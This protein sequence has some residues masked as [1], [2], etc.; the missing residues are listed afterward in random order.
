MDKWM[1]FGDSKE[2]EDDESLKWTVKIGD[3][4][5]AKVN[6]AWDENENHGKPT[7]SVLWM[8]PEVINQKFQ[9][10]YTTKSDVYSFAVVLYELVAGCLPYQNKEP[11]VVCFFL[12]A[13]K[14]RVCFKNFL[15]SFDYYN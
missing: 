2:C 7:G 15:N 6:T 4:G 13:T 14:M 11:S 1:D 8:A 10:P 9:D 12:V 5:L 3:F